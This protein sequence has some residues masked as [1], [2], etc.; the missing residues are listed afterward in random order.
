MTTQG[1]PNPAS[2]PTIEMPEGLEPVY[3]NIARISHTPTEMVLDFSRLLP[4]EPRLKI[5]ARII[6]SPVGAKLLYR[7]LGENIARFEAAFGEIRMP[8]DSK[9]ADDLF[10]GVHPPKPPEGK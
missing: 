1:T 8:G 6:T 7:A 3:S 4:S 5:L 9:L 2:L 10:K